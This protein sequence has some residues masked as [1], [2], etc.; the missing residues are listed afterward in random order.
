[1]VGVST[2]VE[3]VEVPSHVSVQRAPYST[4]MEKPAAIQ[5]L[6]VMW[7]MGDVIT[8]VQ[9]A[10][11]EF[12]ATAEEATDFSQTEQLVETLMN[13]SKET[14]AAMEDVLTHQGITPV[15][16]TLDMKRALIQTPA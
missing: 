4:Q 3:T 11:R 9:R 14:R 16:A 12:P 2:S 13:A 15:Y 7:T 1:M 8:S 6:H 5:R 10:P